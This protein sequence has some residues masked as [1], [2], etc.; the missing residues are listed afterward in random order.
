[1]LPFG[2]SSAPFIFTK[3]LKPLET[4]WRSQGIPIAIFFDDGVGAGCSIE[5]AKCNSSR[6]HSALDKCGFLV[7][8]EISNWE[9]QKNFTWIGYIID[10]QS[11][12][13]SPTEDRI[14]KLYVDLHE[15]CVN[16]ESSCCGNVTQI[17]SRYLHLI[18]NS[19]HSWTSAVFINDQGK[20][21][22]F[23][24]RDN[25]RDLNGV[26]FWPAPFVPSK[27]VYSDASSTGCAAYVQ[28]SSLVFHKNWSA[29]ESQNS[30]TWRELA[31]VKLVLEAFSTNLAGH[32]VRWNTDNQNVVRIVQ[33]GSMVEDL[34]DLALNIFLFTSHHQ[35]QLEASWVPRDK[36]SEADLFS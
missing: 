5:T 36:N 8:Q 3:L 31:A 1:M 28:R 20:Q 24:W 2:L 9:P 16:L 15:L 30:S 29:A 19:R 34:Q 22:L 6:V 26:L 11:G 21:E 25:L 4:H 27:V 33:V 10:T 14:E 18:V 12:F 17:M 7:N 32:R 13:I 35:I 23:F